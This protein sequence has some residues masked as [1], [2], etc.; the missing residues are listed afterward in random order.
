[1]G[2]LAQVG[3][4]GQVAGSQVT[5]VI[6]YT[7]Y[8]EQTQVTWSRHKLHGADTSYM[9]QTQVTQVK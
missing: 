4:R 9:E 3:H 2:A 1:M 7:S 5:Q 8:R 6:G